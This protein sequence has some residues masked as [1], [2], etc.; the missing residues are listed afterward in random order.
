MVCEW[1]SVRPAYPG[2]PGPKAIKQLCVCVCV[3]VLL[4]S[5]QKYVNLKTF[6]T[7]AQHAASS[8][9]QWQ[10]HITLLLVAC[11]LPPD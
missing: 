4:Y 1:V 3:C 10:Y 6:R 7:A 11:H 9:C 5:E 2:S 8:G